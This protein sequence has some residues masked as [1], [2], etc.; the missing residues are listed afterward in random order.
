MFK[1][2]I[3]RSEAWTRFTSEPPCP[4]RAKN[5]QVC[6]PLLP[7]RTKLEYTFLFTQRQRMLI[8]VAQV[9]I[10]HGLSPW[11]LPRGYRA[12]R[13]MQDWWLFSDTA[14]WET[15]HMKHGFQVLQGWGPWGQP[16][17]SVRF[18]DQVTKNSSYLVNCMLSIALIQEKLKAKPLDKELI[19]WQIC[20]KFISV[21]AQQKTWKPENTQSS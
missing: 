16:I 4:S 5:W 12:V 15:D 11:S 19:C 17:P 20:L 7:A 3:R 9:C 1:L 2:F 14:E 10:L 6:F 21:K 13:N 8:V 18:S